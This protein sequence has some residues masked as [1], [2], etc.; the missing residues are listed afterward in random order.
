MDTL[1]NG[2]LV[3]FQIAPAV[4]AFS[5]RRWGKGAIYLFTV[6]LIWFLAFDLASGHLKV[7]P[8]ALVL[9]YPAVWIF[10]LTVMHRR[11]IQLQAASLGLQKA[12]VN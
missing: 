9:I 12:D 2:A 7:L 1:L 4:I 3:A 5:F 8:A 6:P 10:L 11:R